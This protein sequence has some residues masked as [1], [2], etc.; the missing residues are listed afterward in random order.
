MQ[1]MGFAADG[2]VVLKIRPSL[3]EAE[4]TVEPGSCVKQEG[5]WLLKDGVK[6]LTGTYRVPRYGRFLVAR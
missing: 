6:P 3:D 5:L 4:G 2:G 1:A